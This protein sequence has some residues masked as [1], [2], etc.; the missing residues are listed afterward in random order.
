M[1]RKQSEPMIAVCGLD[2]ANECGIFHAPH[3][4]ELA[5]RLTEHF[6]S[7]GYTD[8]QPDWFHCDGC[9][10]DR[11]KHWSANCWILK[12]CVDDKGLEFC[13]QCEDFPCQRLEEWAGKNGRYTV[14]LNRLKE[15]KWQE[16]KTAKRQDS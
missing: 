7:Q 6:R 13:N 10:G 5:L 8:A 11:T 16:G 9:R 14:A 3:D 2:C 12:C 15:G 1:D 4:P